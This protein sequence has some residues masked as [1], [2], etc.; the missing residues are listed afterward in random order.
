VVLPPRRHQRPLRRPRRPRL[1][2]Q[3]RRSSEGRA[4]RRRGVARSA[5]HYNPDGATAIYKSA[6]GGK[7]WHAT[8]DRSNLP[9]SCCGDSQDALAVDPGNPQTLYAAVGDTVFATTDGGKSWQRAANGLPADDVTSLAVDTRRS[10][11]AYASV[12]VDLNQV[13]P[14]A[15]YKQAGAIYKTTDGGRTWRKVFSS[16]GVAKVAVDPARP[17]TIYAAGWA[18]WDKTHDD[19]MRLLRSMDGGRTWATAR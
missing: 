16:I 4:G 9:P 8:G 13:K 5:A 3:A 10:G 19:T 12:M 7:T 14:N 6:D 2:E 15:V 17:S 11:T 18:R 1:C